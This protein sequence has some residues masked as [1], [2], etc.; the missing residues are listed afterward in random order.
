MASTSAGIS[1]PKPGPKA[2]DTANRPALILRDQEAAHRG[3]LQDRTEQQVRMPPMRSDSRPQACRLKKP[4]RAAP[5]A[6]RRR[7]VAEMPRSLQCDQMRLRHRHGHAAQERRKA[8]PARTRHWDASRRLSRRRRRGRASVGSS[9]GVL[10]KISG[11]GTITATEQRVADHGRA[12]A[13]MRWS[14]RK[15]SA[16]RSRRDSRRWKSA[17]ARSR[18]GGRTSG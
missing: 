2:P 11:S 4:R 1:A 12:P 3:A 9:G 16:R 14:A 5:T 10:R 8:R 7:C 18:G 15:P 17:P 13:E 6:W